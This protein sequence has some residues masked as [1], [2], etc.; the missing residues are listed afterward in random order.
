[1]PARLRS[2]KVAGKVVQERVEELKQQAE[3]AERAL[4]EFKTAN[5][6]VG[7]DKD[8]LSHGQLDILGH[9]LTTAR[10]AMAEARSRMERLARDP[11]AVALFTPDNELISKLRSELMDLSIRAKDIEKRVG[12]DHLAAVKIRTRME[13]VREAIAEEQKRISG[14]FNKDYELARARY[15]E[16]SAT[17]SGVLGEE[18]DNSK[19]LSQLRG[20]ER[21]ADALRSQYD[22]TLQQVSEIEQG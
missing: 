1:M 17:V 16:L 19:V 20:L 5:N 7:T 14:S 4:F 12:K 13:E 2:T 11:D 21:A 8:T 15:D 18:G 22:R 6:L 3:D 10:L 9:N